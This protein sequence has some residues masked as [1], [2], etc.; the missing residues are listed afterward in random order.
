MT[1]SIHSREMTD[2][3]QL[4]D[5]CNYDDATR[6]ALH[7]ILDAV[8]QFAQSEVPASLAQAWDHAGV[9]LD[10]AQSRAIL[11]AG[12]PE[13]LRKLRELGYFGINLEE[14]HGGMALPALAET[15][16]VERLSR[17][18]PSLA[19]FLA[20]HYTC[21][22][23]IRTFGTPA[24][25]EHFLPQMS[26]TGDRFILGG[27][28]Y[29]EPGA[30][31]SLGEARCEARPAPPSAG[32]TPNPGDV[33]IH[34]RK[35]FITSGGLAD[36]FVLLARTG[37][38]GLSTW[39]CTPYDDAGKPRAGFSIPKLERKIRLHASPTA[40]LLFDGLTIPANRRLGDA[41]RGLSHAL[42]GLNSGRLGIAAQAL[43]IASAA[44]ADAFEYITQR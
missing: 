22:T 33:A 12:L 30:G 32:P 13:V 36:L 26:G 17:Q 28:A 2:W 18:C 25:Q 43:G 6:S 41:G 20:V 19:L 37:D 15:L 3:H 23:M 42:V 9:T 14:R 24:Q 7:T 38:E 4:L 35:I 21:S 44:F 8:D 39:L 34:G 40:E 27:L 16:I 29:T 31:S 5:G 1:V 11:P 10:T